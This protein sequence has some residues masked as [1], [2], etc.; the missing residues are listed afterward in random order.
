MT[1]ITELIGKRGDE[2]ERDRGGPAESS[3][4]SNGIKR[5]LRLMYAK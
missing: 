1:F 2:T 3:V 5:K 4:L